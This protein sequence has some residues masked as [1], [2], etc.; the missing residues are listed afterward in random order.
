MLRD[1]LGLVY[2]VK[3][4]LNIDIRNEISSHYF[5]E[6]STNYKNIPQL[7][8]VIISIIKSLKLST[9]QIENGKTKF[10][11]KYELKKFNNLTSYSTYYGQYLLHKIPIIERS[12]LL[13][14]F[15]KLTIHQ[16][17]NVLFNFKKDLLNT[18]VFFYYSK[19]N[20]NNVLKKKLGNKIKY[21]VL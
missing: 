4:E 17:E 3:L 5:I 15:Q 2:N 12:T 20:M 18:G 19:K 16:I 10:L 21:I 8:S 11:V 14:Q 6:S 9:E 13:Q 7:I 1:T